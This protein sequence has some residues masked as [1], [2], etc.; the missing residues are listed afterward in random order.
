MDERQRLALIVEAV[1]YCQRVRAMG[2]SPAGYTKALREPVFFLWECR[3][4]RGKERAAWFRSRASVGMRLGSDVVY[5]HAV[6][7]KYLQ[8]ALMELSEV[9]I[10]SVRGVLHRYDVNVIITKEEDC[11]LT[12]AGY[13][14]KMPESWDHIDPLARYKAVGIEI[15]DNS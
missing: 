1:R 2:M 7:F 8:S 13:R 12:K 3:E 11:R 4:G 6:P 9:T 15:V 5:D 10:E 14:F